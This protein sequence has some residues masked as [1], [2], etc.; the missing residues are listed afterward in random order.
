MC[1]DGFE[2]THPEGTPT[3][4]DLKAVK[5]RMHPE[6]TPTFYDLKAVKD[7]MLWE[8]ARCRIIA[9]DGEQEPGFAAYPGYCR[10]VWNDHVRE[11]SE[12]SLSDGQHLM[13]VVLAVENVVRTLCRP[14]KINLASLGNVVP[15]LHWHVIPR[16][17]DDPCFPAP[18]WGTPCRK[19]VARPAVNLAHLA[20][21]LAEALKS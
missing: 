8:D 2:R 9:V 18:I 3:F 16:W 1:R 11:M 17:T 7:R 6:G 13:A 19:P 5:D 21:Y 10:V 20:A 15:H 14:D 4:Y 12:L